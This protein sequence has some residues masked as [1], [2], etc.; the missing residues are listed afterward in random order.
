MTQS[1]HPFANL[2]IFL[3]TKFF[4]TRHRNSIYLR[5]ERRGGAAEK[6]GPK[7]YT[8]KPF[9]L[10]PLRVFSL[11]YLRC[12]PTALRSH[13]FCNAFFIIIFSAELLVFHFF[14]LSF[15]WFFILRP[16]VVL[17]YFFCVRSLIFVNHLL[18]PELLLF[19]FVTCSCW[20]HCR[21]DRHSSSWV[22]LQLS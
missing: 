2:L 5:P 13:I 18:M 11:P 9:S 20:G 7:K 15:V 22:L 16:F 14:C 1:P 17:F 3:W 21:T 8:Q 12:A 4:K 19:L 10:R 6:V